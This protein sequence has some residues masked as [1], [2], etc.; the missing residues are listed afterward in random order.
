VKDDRGDKEILAHKRRR[1]DALFS[2]ILAGSL[3]S[4]TSELIHA[5]RTR[6]RDPHAQAR[7]RRASTRSTRPAST[8][9]LGYSR[10]SR[11]QLGRGNTPE[12]KLESDLVVDTNASTDSRVIGIQTH[13]RQ[14]G[15]CG[16]V[17]KLKGISGL[18]HFSHYPTY[19][20]LGYD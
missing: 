8:D 12:S 19:F 14:A 11:Q 6:S 15:T 20:R 5:P 3:S 1:T 7:A 18:S 13:T 17:S 2:S 10:Y 16:Q 4:S 9:H